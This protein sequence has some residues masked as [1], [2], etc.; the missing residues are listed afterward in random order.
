MP[1]KLQIYIKMLAF[2]KAFSVNH[3]RFCAVN[4]WTAGSL[5]G[6]LKARKGYPFR[7]ETAGNSN[8]ETYAL[9]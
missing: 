1:L 4:K 7:E 6:S 3:R 2:P 5:R 9:G 8:N